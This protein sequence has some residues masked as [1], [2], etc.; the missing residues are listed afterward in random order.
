LSRY[1]DEKQ[2]VESDEPYKTMGFG[3]E[4]SGNLRDIRSIISDE[5][6]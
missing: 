2:T 5:P 1:I 6:E 3:F 4:F